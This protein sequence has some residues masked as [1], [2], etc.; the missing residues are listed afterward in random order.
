MPGSIRSP[1]S[2]ESGRRCPTCLVG[3]I[4]FAGGDH[5]D[6]E[7]ALRPG[8]AVAHASLGTP[9]GSP[10]LPTLSRGGNVGLDEVCSRTHGV[11][12]A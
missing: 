2:P 12:Q 5:A 10:P 11:H 3:R 9:P 7:T 8:D 6:T 4:R 1:M